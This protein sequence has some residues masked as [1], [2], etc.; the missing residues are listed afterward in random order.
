MRFAA[1]STVPY[2][3]SSAKEA[4]RTVFLAR[5]GNRGLGAKALTTVFRD[6]AAPLKTAV[7]ALAA[8]FFDNLKAK[9]TA[10]GAARTE[11]DA[12]GERAQ[13]SLRAR[14]CDCLLVPLDMWRPLAVLITC[15]RQRCAAYCGLDS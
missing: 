4:L 6:V 14:R 11:G 9:V 5:T 12:I 2:A 3:S 10:A 8:A 13:R 1:S 15:P 7:S